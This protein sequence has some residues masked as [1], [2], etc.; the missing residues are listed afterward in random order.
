MAGSPASHPGHPGSAPGGEPRSLSR[1]AH[2]CLPEITAVRFLSPWLEEA[3]LRRI[4]C[5]VISPCGSVLRL[6]CLSSLLLSVRC[7][8][9]LVI[10]PRAADIAGVWL[11]SKILLFL[12]LSLQAWSTMPENLY[13]YMIF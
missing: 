4:L 1:P 10:E 11:S 3:L 8:A 6:F 13:T 9:A 5:R 12:Q 7:F 2:G